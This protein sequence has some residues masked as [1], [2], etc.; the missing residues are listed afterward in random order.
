MF[1]CRL[2]TVRR[3]IQRYISKGLSA[4]KSR[5]RLKNVKLISIHKEAIKTYIE[6]MPTITLN[7]ICFKLQE[8]FGI[9]VSKSTVDR[10]LFLFIKKTF[11]NTRKQNDE[12]T[13]M[14]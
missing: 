8:T 6:K 2:L 3:I 11:F 4:S 14:P 7:Q 12:D 1:G 13:I 9:C 5:G 10:A